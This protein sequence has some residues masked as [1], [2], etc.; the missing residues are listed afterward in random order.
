MSE[1]DKTWLESACVNAS[2]LL[3]LCMDQ[4]PVNQCSLAFMK[5]ELRLAVT[6]VRDYYHRFANDISLAINRGGCFGHYIQSLAYLN[7]Q[8]GP[9][10]SQAFY[11]EM[12]EQA[13]LASSLLAPDDALLLSLWPS[14]LA[15][16]PLFEGDSGP[17]PLENSFAGRKRFLTQ[18]P[19]LPVFKNRGTKASTTRWFSWTSAWSTMDA[20]FH[21]KLFVVT[22]LCMSRGWCKSLGELK[23]DVVIP[24]S[25]KR[26]EPTAAVKGSTASSSKQTAVVEARENI[27]KIRQQCSN[28]LHLSARLMWNS[29]ARCLLRML[30][31]VTRD[32][33]SS[34]SRVTADM[35]GRSSVGEI[36]AGL[37][38]HSWL[39]ALCA[40][41]R[42]TMDGRELVRCGMASVVPTSPGEKM[43][44]DSWACSLGRLVTELLA[45]R[46]ASMFAHSRGYP[47]KL[48]GALG[49]EEQR[50]QTLHTLKEDFCAFAE[51]QHVALEVVK[52]MA[53]KHPL[54]QPVLQLVLIPLLQC[55]FTHWPEESLD[56]IKCV[57]SLG[58]S[59]IIEDANQKLRD[60][61]TRHTSSKVMTNVQRFEER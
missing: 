12:I 10:S 51:M 19:N 22:L 44:Q 53:E 31:L 11:A 2:S 48:A 14:I 26:K 17:E 27:G 54:R 55:K 40:T 1:E 29:E 28:S 30:Y 32:S 58:Q 46:S 42:R 21:T 61:E 33:W 16:N 37:A 60:I 3:V 50:A 56:I 15:D 13:L 4:G 7:V 59:R 20:Y 36:Y 25:K 8:H 38:N 9:W 57:F 35:R 43:L 6:E 5:S 23:S 18:L 47:L 34:F 41:L 45:A 52:S 39:E 24:S 49:T